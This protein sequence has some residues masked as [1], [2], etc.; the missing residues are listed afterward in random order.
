MTGS[1]NVLDAITK[2]GSNLADQEYGNWKNGLS[3]L[4]TQGL[5]A[6]SGIST[7]DKTASGYQSTAGTTGALLSNSTGSGLASSMQGQGI[8]LGNIANGLGINLA[9]NET[10]AAQQV[11]A[12]DL[13]T[14]RQLY[15][16]SLGVAARQDAADSA[17]NG[18]LSQLLMGTPS[19]NSS[20]FLGTLKSAFKL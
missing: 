17:N 20:G 4:G 2:L 10:G 13:A 19:A 6:A 8:A 9:S 11:S 14:Q 18:I 7:N 5:A 3:G 1:G 16:G 15:N 12:N